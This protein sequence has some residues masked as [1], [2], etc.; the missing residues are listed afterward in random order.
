M[1]VALFEYVQTTQ[2]VNDLSQRHE[3]SNHGAPNLAQIAD[4]ATLRTQAPTADEI[5]HRRIRDIAAAGL[6]PSF[7]HWNSHWGADL[8]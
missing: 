3:K 2:L 7:V 8:G 4:P 5:A 6:D 1:S